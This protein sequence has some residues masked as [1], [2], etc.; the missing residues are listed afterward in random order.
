MCWGKVAQ[1]MTSGREERTRDSRQKY[2]FLGHTFSDILSPTRPPLYSFTIFQYF[3][4]IR[5][6][7]R[8]N[9]FI[10]LELS[11]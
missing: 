2:I 3:Y 1:L 7:L 11:G 8:E 10:S 6:L 4:H 5:N 9:T